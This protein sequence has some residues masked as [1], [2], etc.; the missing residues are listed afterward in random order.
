MTPGAARTVT[1]SAAVETSSKSTAVPKIRS[2]SA[3]RAA[4]RSCRGTGP[5]LTT[6]AM[7]SHSGRTSR[8]RSF[9]GSGAIGLNCV[10]GASE[11][12]RPV[13][14]PGRGSAG[15]RCRTL[16]R[17]GRASGLG[18]GVRARPAGDVSR[19][20]RGRPRTYWSINA[21]LGRPPRRNPAPMQ[22]GDNTHYPRS[23][24]RS[25]AQ[26][27]LSLRHNGTSEAFYG[28][29]A[30]AGH[31]R[32]PGGYEPLRQRVLHPALAAR[33]G[34]RRRGPDGPGGGSCAATNGVE[35]SYG[36]EARYPKVVVGRQP[37]LSQRRRQARRHLGSI[38]GC[39]AIGW[40]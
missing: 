3:M 8:R 17:K 29:P 32:Q 34:V 30:S 4:R 31:G 18:A 33:A 23:L 11:P 9:A 5:S 21:H 6:V 38:R 40:R 26:A 20:E 14:R 10:Q 19:G 15:R 1:S 2:S 28:L 12:A 27:T 25:L 35:R 39:R 13:R 7:G 37:V 24:V 36:L 16:V 22:C